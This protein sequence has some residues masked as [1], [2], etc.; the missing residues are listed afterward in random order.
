MVEEKTEEGEEFVLNLAEFFEE[1]LFL[2][3][4]NR[5]ASHTPT[6]RVSN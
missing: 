2:P 1:E 3:P 4:C 5:L 6:L